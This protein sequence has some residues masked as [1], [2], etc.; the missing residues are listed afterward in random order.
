MKLL[1]SVLGGSFYGIAVYLASTIGG[2]LMMTG[3]IAFLIGA[4]FVVGM[5]TVLI[6]PRQ[7]KTK[8]TY[9]LFMPAIPITLLSMFVLFFQLEL[10]VCVCMALPFLVPFGSL[11]GFL[12]SRYFTSRD[13]ASKPQQMMGVAL[14]P[15]LIF[16][17]E[18]QVPKST[19]TYTVRT[20]RV[21]NADAATVWATMINVPVI[22][23]AE[24]PYIFWHDLGVPHPVEADLVGEG[25]GA[26]RLARYDNGLQLQE[27]VTVWEPNHRFVFDVVVD[28]N[29]PAPFHQVGGELIDVL[30]VGFEIEPLA[31]G[32]VRLHLTTDYQLT[33]SLNFYGR[34]WF[35]YFLDQLQTYI[36]DVIEAR[37]EAAY[38][39]ATDK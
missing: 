35:D 12:M 33:T 24:H 18:A 9:A 10:I 27:P 25:V 37:A 11:G 3:S 5:L 30:Q 38:T 7:Y 19:D 2:V 1:V 26:V 20:E 22:S 29:A 31:D 13:G 14:I 17:V 34:L 32:Q 8:T 23:E 6:A 15:F 21:I 28:E 4:P 16:A 39:V 36:L